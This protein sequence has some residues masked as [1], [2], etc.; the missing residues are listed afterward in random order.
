MNKKLLAMLLTFVI[1]FS[2]SATSFANEEI[3][4]NS[5]VTCDGKTQVTKQTGDII[6]VT[7]TLINTDDPS[8]N[9][10]ISS[11]TNEIYFDPAF[12]EY[13]DGSETVTNGITS[14]SAK[15]K[16]WSSKPHDSVSF[17][18]FPMKNWSGTQV[19]G[20]FQLKVIAASGT[21]EIYSKDDERF[22]A[23]NDGYYSTT[24]D[25][26][27]V[28]IGDTVDYIVE[29]N[30][31]V[32]GKSIVLV[33]TNSSD[34]SFTYDDSLM[35]DVT[36]KY[37]KDGYEKAYAIVTD[38]VGS[39]TA[40]DYKD[41]IAFDYVPLDEAYVIEDTGYDINCSGTAD[42]SDVIIVYGVL[43]VEPGYFPS[44]LPE[45]LKADVNNDKCVDSLDT[46]LVKD[47]YIK[48]R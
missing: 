42:I 9:T 37:K 3:T 27:S 33:Y 2:L 26:L 8:A 34:V 25:N 28:T 7:Y 14:L 44:F 23:S 15:F 24:A 13:V 38:M 35:Y 47:E 6:T 11:H 45:I 31:Y 30:Q 20:T 22:I 12:F 41:L 5:L 1:L 4:L 48:S 46:E 39:G 36:S 32:D 18:G 40:E 43:N 21:S 16:D 10:Y 29:A 19:V 17:N